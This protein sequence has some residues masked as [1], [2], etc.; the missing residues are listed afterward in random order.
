MLIF[1]K[2]DDK[3]EAYEEACELFNQKY[4]DRPHIAR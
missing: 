3:L 2:F 1:V 4:P